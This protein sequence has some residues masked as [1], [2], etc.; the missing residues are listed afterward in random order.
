MISETLTPS[1]YDA[2]FAAMKDDMPR[3][4]REIFP[5]MLGQLEGTGVI[6]LNVTDTEIT[7]SSAQAP[8]TVVYR[9][10]RAPRLH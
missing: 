3:M 4:W 10:A 9:V 8:T 7:V 2:L 6:V 1:D 5:Q